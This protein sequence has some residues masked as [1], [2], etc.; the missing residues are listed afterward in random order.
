MP[1]KAG[2]VMGTNQFEAAVGRGLV[3]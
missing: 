1:E 2:T 3:W